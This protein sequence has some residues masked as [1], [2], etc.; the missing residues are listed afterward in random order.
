MPDVTIAIACYNQACFLGEAIESAL[1]QTQPADAI[2]VVDDG[3]HD[4]TPLICRLFPTVTYHRQENGGLSA[5]R[6]TGLRLAATRHIVFLDADDRLAPTMI[7]QALA[8]C[9]DRPDLAFVYGGYCAVDRIGDPIGDHLPVEKADGFEAL[10]HDNF[11]GMHGTV[12]YDTAKLRDV[13]GFDTS[14]GSCEDWDVYLKLARHHP[15][16]AYPGIAAEYRRH[17]GTMSSN[18]LRMIDFGA[19]V[20]RRQIAQGLTFRQEQ[21]ARAGIRFTRRHYSLQIVGDLKRALARSAALLAAGLRADM[22]FLP[23]LATAVLRGAVRRTPRDLPG[24]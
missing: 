8:R 17:E 19:L 2:I 18:A 16:A 23:W 15:I 10:L 1:R 11:I 4:A 6:N 24:R 12:L 7:E 3:S 22:R 13:G 5:A 20:L 9:A 21:A 14:L